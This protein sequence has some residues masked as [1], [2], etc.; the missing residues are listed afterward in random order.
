M[1]ADLVTFRV[2]ALDQVRPALNELAL[3]EECY[4]NA[5]FLQGVE[6]LSCIFA[7]PVIEGDGDSAGGR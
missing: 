2:H 5:V 7:R 6:Q 1:I 4:F 3:D